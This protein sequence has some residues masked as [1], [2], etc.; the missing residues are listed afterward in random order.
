LFRNPEEGQG[1]QRAVVPV[2]MMMMMMMTEGHSPSLSLFLLVTYRHGLHRKCSS[3]AVTFLAWKQVYGTMQL[4]I[5]CSFA[6]SESA[7]HNINKGKA[8]TRN[9]RNQ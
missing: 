1:S 6:N 5:L 4:L 3:V 9:K 8:A 7:R 2:M